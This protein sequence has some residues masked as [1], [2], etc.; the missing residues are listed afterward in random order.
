MKNK[1]IILSISILVIIL[2][3]IVGIIFIPKLLSNKISNESNEEKVDLKKVTPLLYKVTKDG[4]NNTIYLFGSV[5]AANADKYEYPDYINKA[6]DESEYLACE[7]DSTNSSNA[8]E[9]LSYFVYEDGSIVKDHISIDSYNKIVEFFDKHN[10]SFKPYENYKMALIYSLI[11][12]FVIKDAGYYSSG[13]IDAFFLNKAKKD[14]KKV[15]EVE[16]EQFQMNLLSNTSD[17]IF[18][19]LTIEIIDNYDSTVN[20]LKDLVNAWENGNIN[21]LVENNESMN[22][23]DDELN[24]YSEEDIELVT[25]FINSLLNDRDKSMVEVFEEYFNDDKN[26][27]FMVGAGHIVGDNGLAKVL[28]TKGY[29]VELINK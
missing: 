29:N 12:N 11:E 14:N 24:Y 1:K 15:L 3:S 10:Y 19:L 2:L 6:Y 8:L 9:I 18:E 21:K 7:Y 16:S 17:R 25:E 28:E 4:S 22:I 20:E 23:N 26:V 5:H 27:L 13:G